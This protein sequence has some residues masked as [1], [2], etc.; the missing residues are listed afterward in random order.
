MLIVIYMFYLFALTKDEKFI[1]K[2]KKGIRLK[3]AL[4]LE[5]EH[6]K[7]K[8]NMLSLGRIVLGIAVLWLAS[9]L[10]VENALELASSWGVAQSFVG[11]MIIG[12]VP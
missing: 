2:I 10:V 8:Q 11:V 1:S 6:K 12:V 9:K 4:Y 5:H 7:Q 3:G